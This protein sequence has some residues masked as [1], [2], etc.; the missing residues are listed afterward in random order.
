MELEMD[1]SASPADSAVAAVQLQVCA[2]M[3]PALAVGSDDA[4]PVLGT[5]LKAHLPSNIATVITL[6]SPPPLACIDQ[7]NVVTRRPNVCLIECFLRPQ[8]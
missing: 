5:L 7:V 4:P 8:K 2:T 6:F 1:S 3:G